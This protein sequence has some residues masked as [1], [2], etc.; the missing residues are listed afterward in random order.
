MNATSGE[1]LDSHDCREGQICDIGPLSVPHCDG[2]FTLAKYC[3]GD[4]IEEEENEGRRRRC[5]K[6]SISKM[7]CDLLST[8]GAGTIDVSVPCPGEDA[9]C[10]LGP[11]TLTVNDTEVTA[12]FCEKPIPEDGCPVDSRDSSR[13]SSFSFGRRGRGGRGRRF[14]RRAGRCG[15]DVC[16]KVD[17]DGVITEGRHQCQSDL[18]CNVGP[19]PKINRD[20]E[21]EERWYCEQEQDQLASRACQVEYTNGAVTNPR[22]CSGECSLGPVPLSLQ[23]GDANAFFCYHPPRDDLVSSQS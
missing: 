21:I 15:R 10:T 3:S 2:S 23:D 13:A 22:D 16:L 19:V 14:K 12:L 18:G 1:L 20:G 5:K 4:P 9:T 17:E 11:L 8:D 6:P 7:A